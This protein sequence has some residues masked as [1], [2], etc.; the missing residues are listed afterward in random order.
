MQITGRLPPD[1]LQVLRALQSKGF[2]AYVVGGAVRDL[3][4]NRVPKDHD[5]S[6]NATP[7]EIRRIFGR[8]AHIIGRRF[9]LAHVHTS[10]GIFEV[11]TFRRAPTLEERKGRETDSGLMVW[12]DN[13]FG[14][15]EED[16]ERRDFTVNAIYYDPLAPDE[17]SKIVDRVGGLADIR[18]GVVRTIGDPEV[19]MAE[20]P[21]RMLRA[22]KLAGQYG[23][24][25]EERLYRDIKSGA[26]R[27]VLSSQARLLEEIFKIVVKPYTTPIFQACHEIGLLQYLIPQLTAR[28]DNRV[29]KICQAL[30]AVRDR[31]LAEGRIVPSRVTGL[32]AMA[33]P[34][35]EW[36][37][38]HHRNGEPW[39]NFHGIE[40]FLGAW[41]KEFFAPFTLSRYIRAGVC[42]VLLLQPKLRRQP[43]S[44]RVHAHPEYR[45][46]SE[47]LAMY[48]Q[49]TGERQHGAAHQQPD[50][51]EP[52]T[53]AE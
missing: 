20:D 4:L 13:E 27:L 25:M 7:N 11:S 40:S 21:V 35:F 52:R 48:T 15:L 10:A 32:A 24:H 39:E 50:G 2:Q 26:P 16:A 5:I 38:R 9:R 3:L 18:D 14:T 30:L 28:W 45:K 41:I 22:C 44:R 23:F 37:V 53:D 1:T 43:K 6:T 47:L 12:R 49:A 19:R 34:F 42:S 51:V 36:D 31:E 29:G 46:A 17:D 8:R 33:L